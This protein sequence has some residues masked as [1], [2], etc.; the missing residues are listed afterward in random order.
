M[1]PWLN[2]ASLILASI[3]FTYYYVKSV[4]PAS[5][6]REIGHEAYSK[7]GAYRIISS[8]CMLLA[9][10]NFVLY[11]FFPLP[12]PLPKTFA[13][14][15]KISVLVAIVIAIPSGYLMWRGV[16]DAGQETI[17]PAKENILY[18]GIYERIRHP[19][20]VGE[21]PFW[22]VI[23]FALNSPFLVVFSFLYLPV[24]L[25]FCWA[26]EQDLLIRYGASYEEY[27]KRVGFW[28]PKK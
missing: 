17:R 18:S 27:R 23:G 13:W 20:A 26:E 25:Y 21:F 16:K 8:A 11:Y 12:L 9:A 10:A 19:Q 5:L 7:C 4:R 6:E 24:W 3:L 14:G 15:W 28:F 2:L 1:I 22:W